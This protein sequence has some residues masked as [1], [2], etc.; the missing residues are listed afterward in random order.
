MYGYYNMFLL[1]S[2]DAP[3]P[4]WEQL[5][6]GL[7]AVKTVVHGL[8]D[9]IQNHS[10]KGADPQQVCLA[11][12]LHQGWDQFS[13]TSKWIKTWE[14]RALFSWVVRSHIP[15]R[16]SYNCLDLEECFWFSLSP[17]WHIFI[18]CK[19]EHFTFHFLFSQTRTW[20]SFN[21]KY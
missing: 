17:L 16:K 18:F 8:V 14:S 7:V 21:S 1:S 5:E 2:V 4:T 3:P 13:E 10:K 12:R 6:N 11:T 9:F 15:W 19:P 20:I